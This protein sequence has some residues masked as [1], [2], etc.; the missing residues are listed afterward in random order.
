MEVTRGSSSMEEDSRGNEKNGLG[1]LKGEGG[2][3]RRKGKEGE[4]NETRKS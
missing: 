1:T 4:I 2:V 3:M